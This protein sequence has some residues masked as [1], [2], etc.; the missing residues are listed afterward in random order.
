[1]SVG[2]QHTCR[3]VSETATL[4]TSLYNAITVIH[5]STSITK[6]PRSHPQ[7]PHPPNQG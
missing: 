4:A 7:L 2:T 6:G 1:M 5:M 3:N